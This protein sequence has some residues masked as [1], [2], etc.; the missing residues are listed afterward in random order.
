MKT[1]VL[2]KILLGLYFLNIGIVLGGIIVLN[3]AEGT[4]LNADALLRLNDFTS[5]ITKY[6]Q[7]IILADILDKFRYILVFVAIYVLSYDSLSFR[8]QKSNFFIWILGILNTILMFLFSFFYTPNIVEVF[9]QEPK[10]MA[11]P[12]TESL[13]NSAEIVLKI[14]FITLLISFFSRVIITDKKHLLKIADQESKIS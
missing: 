1:L 10:V 13:L 12:Q 4:I 5:S 8:F 7:G 14:L 6:D 3:F 2:S 11:A 9:S